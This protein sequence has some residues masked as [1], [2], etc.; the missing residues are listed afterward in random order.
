LEHIAQRVLQ[1]DARAVARLISRLENDAPDAIPL[2]RAIFHATGKAFVLG[3]TGAPG[4]GKSTLVDGLIRQARQA[5]ATVAVLAVDPSSPFTG[6]AILG[7]RIRMQAH[8]NDT[9]VFIRS[10]GARGQLGGLARA[11]RKAIHVLDAAGYAMIIVETVGVGQ[12]ELDIA[13]AA[14][15][16]VVVVTPGM[17]DTVQTLKAGILEIADVFALNKADQEGAA[18][19]LRALRGMLHMGPASEWDVP[20]VET[21]AHEAAGLALLWETISRHR[22]YLEET[23]QLADRRSVRLKGEVLDLVERGLRTNVLKTL[24]GSPQFDAVLRSVIAR[25]CDPET[26]ACEI[27]GGVDA[28]PERIG[29][30]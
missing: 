13:A 30:G 17:G 15:T 11:T 21:R 3:V 23:G 7:D 9:G 24:A 1:G 26:G 22:I 28:K 29:N 20:V 19:T 18:Q 5:G 8:A 27:L 16:T 14:D 2:L 4:A 6:G 10:M 12:S 25:N